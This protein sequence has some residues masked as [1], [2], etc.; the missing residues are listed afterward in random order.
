[1]IKSLPIA[2]EC[3]WAAYY[4]QTNYDVIRTEQGVYFGRES[5]WDMHYTTLISSLLSV[6]CGDFLFS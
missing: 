3:A 1:M 2:G 6:S 5:L 4:F